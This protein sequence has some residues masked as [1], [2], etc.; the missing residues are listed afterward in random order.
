M[1]F[2]SAF[3]KMRADCPAASLYLVKYFPLGLVWGFL[4]PPSEIWKLYGVP[5]SPASCVFPVNHVF[6]LKHSHRGEKHGRR[7]PFSREREVAVRSHASA[8]EGPKL[9]ST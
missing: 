1:G 3:G 5:K 7:F 8:S 6:C 4:L 9:S 2:G